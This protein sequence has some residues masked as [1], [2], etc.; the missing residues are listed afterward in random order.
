[1]TSR[2]RVLVALAR[3][4]P[5]RLPIDLG[6]TESSGLTGLAWHR[7]VRHLG[8][9]GPADGP[10][11]V[12]PY[13]QVARV[14]ES[15]RRRFRIDTVPLFVEPAQWVAGQLG[16]GSPCRLP[17]GW[18]IRVEPNGDRVAIDSAGGPV[19][20]MPAGGFYF[21]PV[22]AAL[23]DCRT[24]ADVTRKR[25]AIAT[26]DLPD[27]CDEGLDATIARARRLHAQTDLAVVFNF[28]C[29]LLHG[30]TGLRGYEQFMMDL[31]LDR[32]LAEA[33]LDTLLEAYLERIDRYAPR[34]RGLVDVVLFNDDL[35]TQAG[36]MISP[37]AYRE[38]IQPRQARL[39]GCAKRAFGTPILFHSC[40]SVRAFIPGLIAAGVDGLNPVQV[41]ANGME[42]AG[43]KRDF[44]RDICFWGG[45]CDSQGVLPRGTPDEV[46]AEV[47]RRVRD[48]APGGGFV[49]V[50]VHN[51]Q[52]DV[53]P[54]NVAAMLDE[55]NEGGRGPGAGDR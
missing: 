30:G 20:R 34:L 36:P 45:G 43:L 26:C 19:A 16:D 49:F 22:G 13:Q 18:R 51:V 33:V 47:R 6:G 2:Q 11:I 52:P 42:S 25:A 35:G 28:C 39:F 3:R 46:R 37:T 15:L 41:S 5:D 24:P 55:A 7:L 17:A 21:D 9:A 23:A 48:F 53:P 54:E 14:D 4:Q 38:L 29:H 10:D 12:D 8:A 1:M 44:G 31:A 32:P 40:G 27:F 50:Q